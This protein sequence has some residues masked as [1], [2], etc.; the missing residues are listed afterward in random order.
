MSWQVVIASEAQDA[1]A[2]LSQP[3]RQRLL[4]RLKWFINNFDSLQHETLTGEFSHYYKYRIGD[5]RVLYTFSATD[6]AIT[7]RLIGHRSN[8]YKSR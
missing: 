2:Q 7:I 8:I 4:K 6:Q 3:V 1:L 5:Y